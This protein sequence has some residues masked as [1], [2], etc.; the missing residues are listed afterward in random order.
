[1][2]RYTEALL[3]RIV[4]KEIESLV[5]RDAHRV[6]GGGPAMYETF[7][8]HKKGAIKV[9]SSHGSD[10]AALEKR[11]CDAPRCS[12]LQ[13]GLGLAQILRPGLVHAGVRDAEP[14]QP[15]TRGVRRRELAA[16]IGLA[17]QSRSRAV[18]R[19]RA[20]GDF[21]DLATLGTDPPEPKWRKAKAAAALVAVIGLTVLD[22]MAA[23]AAARSR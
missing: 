11:Q 8:N 6:A 12:A 21:L 19:S 20:A 4:N 17:R 22:L 16:G 2:P 23:Q 14:D 3:Q 9:V 10:D 1:M 5:H 15:R 7:R 18:L 13:P